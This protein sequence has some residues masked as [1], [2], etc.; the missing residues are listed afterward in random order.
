M[1]FYMIKKGITQMN[2]KLESI[3]DACVNTVITTKYDIETSISKKSS[4]TAAKMGFKGELAVTP[5]Q[6]IAA[7]AVLCGV[8]IVASIARKKK[9]KK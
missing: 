7:G 4:S 3:L 1:N 5:A 9:K 8:C 6:I 2:D